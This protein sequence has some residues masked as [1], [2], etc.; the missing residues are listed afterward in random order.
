MDIEVKSLD[1]SRITLITLEGVFQNSRVLNIMVCT[2][3]HVKLR[4]DGVLLGHERGCCRVT[5]TFV[6]DSTRRVRT[7]ILHFRQFHESRLG[8]L[9][10]LLSSLRQTLKLSVSIK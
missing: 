1:N 2:N 7:V 6:I 10:H 3:T 5:L 4:L 8:F 9:S